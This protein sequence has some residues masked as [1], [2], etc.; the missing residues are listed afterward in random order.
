MDP[1]DSESWRP[2]ATAITLHVADGA[3]IDV[4]VKHRGFVIDRF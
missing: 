3:C 1:I 4:F 2:F